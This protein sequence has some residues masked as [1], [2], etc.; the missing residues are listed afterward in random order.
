MHEPKNSFLIQLLF[1]LFYLIKTIKLWLFLVQ[2]KFIRY[3]F[4]FSDEPSDKPFLQWKSHSK[5][6]E[7]IYWNFSIYPYFLR[8]LRKLSGIPVNLWKNWNHFNRQIHWI[9]VGIFI[10][11]MVYQQK[12]VNTFIFNILVV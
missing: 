7:F 4:F 10:R 8:K 1:I 11:R 9:S 5:S 2:L 6:Y 3:W 12:L